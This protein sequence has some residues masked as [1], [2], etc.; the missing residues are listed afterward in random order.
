MKLKT[1][2]SQSSAY[3]IMVKAE[4]ELLTR[5]ENLTKELSQ[6]N[7][8]LLHIEEAKKDLEGGNKVEVA[9]R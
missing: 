5:K 8:S 9:T 2:F 6:V 7:T 3:G 4:K 1:Q